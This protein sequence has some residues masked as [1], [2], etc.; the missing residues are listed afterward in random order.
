MDQ[1]ELSPIIEF[2]AKDYKAIDKTITIDLSV[3]HELDYILRK[4]RL[5][6]FS[7]IP[8]ITLKSP[9]GK[10]IIFSNPTRSLNGINYKS[11]TNIYLKLIHEN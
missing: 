6:N 5:G 9:T 10:E 8:H 1:L 4:Y 11:K 7:N 3:H 2:E